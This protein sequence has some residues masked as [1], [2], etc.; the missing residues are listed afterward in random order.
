MF[1]KH[2][3]VTGRS[4]NLHTSAM[5]KEKELEVTK[6]NI[7]TEFHIK[8]IFDEIVMS[9]NF[10]KDPLSKA[11]AAKIIISTCDNWLMKGSIKGSMNEKFIL[12]LKETCKNAQY[13][14]SKVL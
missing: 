3:T 6:T 14:L 11:N 9:F 1:A 5:Q 2:L 7:N 12:S 13:E 8:K 10:I 4:S